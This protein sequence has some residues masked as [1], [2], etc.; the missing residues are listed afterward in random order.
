ME[1]PT[2]NIANINNLKNF[3]KF[4]LMVVL[5]FSGITANSQTFLNGNFEKNNASLGVDEINLPNASFN[6]KMQ[7]TNAFGTYGDMDIVNTAT[8]SGLAQD[9]S[10]YVALTGGG[11][12]A[13]AMEL[14]SPLIA[15][16]TYTIS[17]YDRGS[18]GFTPQPI[19]IG[20]SNSNSAFGT[21]VYTAPLP[22][23]AVWNKRT[24]TFTATGNFQYITVQLGGA[25]NIGEW[26]QVD[27][28]SF[29]NSKN[30][31]LTGIISGGPFCACTTMN[32]PFTSTGTF[33]S[34][35]VYTAQLSDANGNFS[36]P[37]NI[38][39][40]T[41]TSNSGIIVANI[42][43]DAIGGFDYRIRVISNTPGVIGT[44]NNED[45]TINST[46]N[47]VVRIT[48][49]RTGAINAGTS[50]TFTASAT[51]GGTRPVYQW[52]V[53]GI[54]TGTDASTYTSSVLKNG[55]IITVVMTSDE[56]CASVS[57][58]TSNAITIAV[59]SFLVAPTVSISASPYT[60]IGKGE[61][62][63]FTAVSSNGGTNPSYQWQINGVNAGNNSFSFTSTSLN[64]GDIVS[65][66]LTSN[67]ANLSA[68][69][70]RSNVIKI[71][72]R[73]PVVT[74][75]GTG[76]N[77]TTVTT[78][79]KKVNHTQLKAPMKDL[80]SF[81]WKTNKRI[82]YHKGRIGKVAIHNKRNIK[83]C[84]KF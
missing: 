32:V 52:Q 81:K 47:P 55:D 4:F 33:T 66:I 13:I 3:S 79:T 60:T 28:F 71:S 20:V 7:N 59:N 77:T 30:T 39:T 38:G 83:R 40:L 37:V 53:N 35:N 82:V 27:N 68:N 16:K 69:N 54:N 74:T 72:V 26:A 75:V 67:A 44:K 21:A 43:C 6:S 36:N 64:N 61:S 65:V 31:I 41:S 51:N 1:R 29:V 50:V 15:G 70:V 42:P 58:V 34:G 5:L 9:G 10:W 18:T 2:R 63:T 19:Q 76:N 8:Y 23:I 25:Y 57:M 49:N 84:F 56:P 48:A 14:S 62:V 11:S 17:F 24:F 22:E 73:P 78:T 45:I 12:D 46:A 80:F